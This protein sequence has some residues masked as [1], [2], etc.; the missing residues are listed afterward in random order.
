M[1]LCLAVLSVYT[2][3]T[4]L[5]PLTHPDTV[6]T[7]VAFMT[8]VIE[9]LIDRELILIYCKQISNIT[10]AQDK[11]ACWFLAMKNSESKQRVM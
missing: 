5:Y 11:N 6:H 2:E 10:E 9:I 7:H 3:C 1:L 4:G 8:S